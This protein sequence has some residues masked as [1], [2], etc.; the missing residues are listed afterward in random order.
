MASRSALYSPLVLFPNPEKPA[1]L[2]ALPALKKWLS[3]R[4]VQVLPRAQLARAKA[5]V[6]LG[7]D[8]T[9]LAAARE[10]AGLNLPLL[11]VNVGRLGF[12]TATDLDHV[13][14]VLDRLLRGKL[15]A[16]RRMM[17]QMSG[18]TKTP[19]V[20]LND[21]V[22]HGRFSGRVVRLTVRVNG[23][24]LGTYVG[25]GLIV[26]TP[27][28]STAYSMAAGGPLVSPEMDM[29]LL[30]PVCAHSLN[31]RPVILPPESLIEVVLDPRHPGE[32]LAVSLDG[33]EHFTV[34]AAQRIQIRV[35]PERTR[36]FSDGDQPFFALLR[37]KLSWGE[38]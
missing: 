5:V 12:L 35:A 7:G 29:L 20:A 33:Q 19:R 38:R 34:K 16:T 8:G 1:A 23:A 21:C 37:E 17:L 10:A 15:V 9:L 2:K 4:G 18:P 28:G 26:S 11:G 30:T 24:P 14:P 6:A 32:R 31:Q 25:D 13:H 3:A 27:T 36:I 22:I